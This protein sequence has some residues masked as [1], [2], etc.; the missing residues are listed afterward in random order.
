M[1][2][3]ETT[4]LVTTTAASIKITP[5][6]L[7]ARIGGNSS[8]HTARCTR[9]SGETASRGYHNS[10][11]PC[12]RPRHDR[13]APHPRRL[14]PG[15]ARIG[16]G[17]HRTPIYSDEPGARPDTS[18]A[19]TLAPC[20]ACG[21]PVLTG[22]TDRGDLVPVEPQTMTYALLWS[23]GAR[24]PRLKSGRGYP[25]HQCG[26][27]SDATEEER[28]TGPGRSRGPGRTTVVL[29]GTPLTEGTLDD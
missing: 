26:R 20:K 23:S 8:K 10:L 29:Q 11:S 24:H 7:M 18:S 16:P 25:A 12:R 14:Y 5:R 28:Y 22:M 27:P 1:A 17:L 13:T 3:T 21:V 9:P 19:V 2:G 6:G 4:E 15:T